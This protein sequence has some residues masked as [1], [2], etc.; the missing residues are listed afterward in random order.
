MGTPNGRQAGQQMAGQPAHQTAHR[1]ADQTAQ[2]TT[3]QTHQTHQPGRTGQPA[4]IIDASVH[5]FFESNGDLR[6]YLEEPFR[7]RGI[8]DVEMD[9]FGAP[10][11]EYVPWAERPGLYPGSDPEFAGQQLFGERGVDLAVLHPM[12]RG[13]LPDRHLTTA[14]LAAHNKML[15]HRWLEHDSY[16]ARFRGTIR[17]DPED[18]E[19]ALTELERWR[20][21]PRWSR[22]A[23]RSSRTRCTASRS[24]SPCG[25]PRPRPA[26]RW[27]C[28]SRPGPASTSRRRRRDRRGPTR[29][30]SGSWG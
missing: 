26:C 16:G 2:P 5:V 7:S 6:S 3:H 21:H 17:L 1:A 19:G 13:C 4:R 18:I 22:S 20:E 10:G 11:G 30:T 24:S 9:W 12:T 27:P 28:T 23:S 15:A 29:S 25:R 14:V 8:P